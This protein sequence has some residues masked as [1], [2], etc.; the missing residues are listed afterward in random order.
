MSPR[1]RFNGM[2]RSRKVLV[3]VVA[4]GASLAIAGAAF[5]FWT[6][7]GSG[8]GSATATTPS[9]L[10][11]NQTN[12]AINNLFPGGPAQALSGTF[13]NPNSGPVTITTLTASVV[14]FTSQANSGKPA[15]TEADFAISGT[16]TINPTAVPSGTGV[17]SWSG[18]SVALTNTALNQDNCKGVS[19]QIAYT[20]S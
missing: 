13:N 9:A 5:A 20:A 11:V 14:P 8:T 12:A 6:G 7:G 10:V 17:G 19:I 3:A 2:K 16:P 18:Y 1:R 4:G 15:C